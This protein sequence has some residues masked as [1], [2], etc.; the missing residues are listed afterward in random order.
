MM[1]DHVMQDLLQ[2]EWWKHFRYS[3]S[4]T[5]D[6]LFKKINAFSFADSWASVY[7]SV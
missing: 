7:R 6:K 1:F 3:R 4:Y 2:N 5:S